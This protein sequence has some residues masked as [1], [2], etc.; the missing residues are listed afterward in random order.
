MHTNKRLIELLMII[1]IIAVGLLV[2]LEDIRDWEANPQR[3]LYKGEPL[4]TTFDG[5]YYLTLSRDLAEHTYQSIDEKRA[6]PD[7]PPRP[8]PPP[9]LSSIGNFVKL[10]T[11][12][13]FNWIAALTPA[14]LGLLLIFPV[15]G[16]GR[17]YGG[18][19]MAGASSL[20]ALLS[21]YYVYRS[22]LGWFDTDCMNVTFAMTA[23]FTAL[24]FGENTG[25]RR[26]FWFGGALLNYV[27][28]LWWWDQTPQ[29]VTAVAL[30]PLATAFCFFYRPPKKECL[31]FMAILTTGILAILSLKGMDL[32]IKTVQG[33]LSSYK[34]ISKQ[35]QGDFPN[36]GISISEQ[37]IPSFKEIVTKTTDS[38]YTFLLALTGLILL[39]WKFRMKGIYLAVPAIIAGLSFFFA[40]RFMIFLAPTL[41]LGS[42]FLIY[43]IWLLKNKYRVAVVATPLIV[44]I[45]IFP[46]FQKSMAKTFWPK[47][48]PYIIAGM[49]EAS[50]KTPKNAVIWAWWD[51]GYPMIYWSRRATINDGQ[52]HGGERSVF[53]GLPFTVNNDRLAANFMTFFVVRGINHGT[54]KVY[55][56][57]NGDVSKGFN[58][59]KAIMAAGPARA[60]KIIEN[61]N[62]ESQGNLKTTDD[63]LRFF[64]PRSSRPVYLFLDWRLT[65]TNYWW[66]WLGSWNPKIH[67]GIHPGYLAFYD[68]IKKGDKITGRT[69]NSMALE[70][71]LKN[72]IMRFGNKQAVLKKVFLRYAQKVE[73]KSYNRENG[74]IFEANFPRGFGAGMDENMA[75]S[76]F[77]RLFLRHMAN[78]KYF[79]PVSLDTPYFQI[80]KVKG[81]QAEDNSSKNFLSKSPLNSS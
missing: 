31:I 63:W 13:S 20:F 64:F 38:S 33:I 35:V 78:L 25:P 40:K 11:P 74:L 70:V 7:C 28:F 44:L 18:P 10:I 30:L 81:D 51:H 6:V 29:V 43:Q 39:F 46:S 76:L 26:Y 55:K 72:G 16:L 34:Y 8:Q 2:R 47:E 59:I 42:G 48:P 68:L 73:A 58:L 24:K 52:V 22:S 21:F 27:L 56:A 17:F 67:D 19:I 32:P 23:V 80:W 66:F 49:V 4:L 45:M 15:Y 14:F 9:L 54:H 41:A 50:K 36:I 79:E 62:L 37:A 65:V 1:L 69:S 77:N 61:A 53:N 71:D 3:A 12:L 57:C 75:E 60:R 5:Y